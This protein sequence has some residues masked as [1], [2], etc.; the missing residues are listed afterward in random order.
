MCV[1]I[2]SLFPRARRCPL[3]WRWRR[4]HPW[5]DSL[6]L[7]RV[8]PKS[9]GSQPGPACYGRGGAAPTVTDANV[10]LGYIDPEYFL[11]GEI[12]LDRAAA[13]TAVGAI[14]SRLDV[15]PEEAAYA[16]YD[17]VNEA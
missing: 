5:F 13:G 14:A 1:R 10:L 7:L 17:V 11:G 2:A 4:Q 9:A 15:P 12:R 8:G 16:I 3:D 6:D